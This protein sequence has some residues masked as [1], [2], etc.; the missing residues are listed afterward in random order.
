[1]LLQEL[2]GL[3]VEGAASTKEAFSAFLQ[4]LAD[5]IRSMELN[6]KDVVKS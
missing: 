1:V 5:D 6:V 2:G 4:A 3:V